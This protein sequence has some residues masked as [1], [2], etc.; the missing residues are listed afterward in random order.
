MAKKQIKTIM[1]LQ[2]EA[3]KATPAPP[4][5]PALGQHGVP[6]QDFCNRFNDMTKKHMGYQ[7]RCEL[8]VYKDR[9]FEIELKGIPTAN[10]IQKEI[11][12]KKGSA[13]PN[14][15]KVGKLT[16]KQIRDI[17]EKKI[18]DLNTKN[19]ESAM[20]IVE[21]TAKSMGLEIEKE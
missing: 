12:L 4:I 17:A 8:K 9:T 16:K 1:K 15:I 10:L 11:G 13:E 6:I 18:D 14:Q 3:G 19:I 20:K 2:I 21:G 5:G 7:V